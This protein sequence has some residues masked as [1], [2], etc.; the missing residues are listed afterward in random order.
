MVLGDENQDPDRAKRAEYLANLR[1]KEKR[2]RK[3]GSSCFVNLF[4]LV[5]PYLSSSGTRAV[6]GSQDAIRDGSTGERCAFDVIIQVYV[7]S[8]CGCT[9]ISLISAIRDKMAARDQRQPP[10]QA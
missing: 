6:G 3:M 5:P 2:L 7:R 8:M 1:A 9:L 4:I 10:G